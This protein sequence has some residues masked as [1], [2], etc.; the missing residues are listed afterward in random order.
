[1]KTVCKS[2]ALFFIFAGQ[3]MASTTNLTFDQFKTDLFDTLGENETFEGELRNSGQSCRVKAE[4]DSQGRLIISI[5][6]DE[7]VEVQVSARPNSKYKME[8]DGSSND[9][10]S[11][12]YRFGSGFALEVTYVRMDDLGAY[13]VVDDGSTKLTCAFEM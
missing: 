12:T 8:S 10:Y 1:M 4:E 3:T 11:K 5:S 9:V 13:W 2:I 6:S 7:G